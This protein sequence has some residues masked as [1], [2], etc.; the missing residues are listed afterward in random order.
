MDGTDGFIV[1][2]AHLYW[3]TFVSAIKSHFLLS[4]KGQ[5]AKKSNRC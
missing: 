3:V 2:P 1:Y 4:L 5:E